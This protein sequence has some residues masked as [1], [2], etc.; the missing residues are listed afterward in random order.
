MDVLSLIV[1]E[2]EDVNEL[3]EPIKAHIQDVTSREYEYRDNSVHVTE[4]LYCLRKAY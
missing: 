2:S 1:S 3:P 4:L